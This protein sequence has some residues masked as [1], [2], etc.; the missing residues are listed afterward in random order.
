MDILISLADHLGFLFRDVYAHCLYRFSET[1][2]W[3]WFIVCCPMITFVEVPRYLVPAA[4]LMFRRFFWMIPD[5][6][7]DKRGFLG[8]TP[9]VSIL[10]V[11]LNEGDSIE[12]AIRTVLEFN[13]PDM[14]II[15]VDDNSTDDMYAKAKPYADRGQIRLF[16]NTSA[17]GR[18][19]RPTASNIA[20]A[21]ATGDY[22]LSV[23]ADTAFD[24]NLLFH[25]IGSFYKEDV[26]VVAANLKVFN[27]NESF[28]TR[29]QNLEYIQS[30]SLWKNWLNLL[31]WNMQASGACGAFRRE[32]LD[33]AG[34]WNPEL[35]EDADISLQAN[36]A[37]WRSYFC[38]Q[39]D[40]VTKV[41]ATW[42]ALVKQ[43]YRWDRGT[44][45]TYY[46]KHG[47][48]AKFWRHG[49]NNS[50]EIIFEY[51]CTVVLGVVYPAWFLWLLFSDP[52][53]LVGLISITYVFY[54]LSALVSVSAGLLSRR[55]QPEDWKCLVDCLGFPAY[56]EI[57][58]W[59]RIYATYLSLLRINYED[60]Y[61]PKTA[62]RNAPRW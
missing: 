36:K 27:I 50:G 14:E 30:I 49:W 32:C 22:I 55:S 23:D 44:V 48:M 58:R 19:G 20:L 4:V 45:R 62:W 52:Y 16:K 43:R 34:A 31:G 39:A 13:Y 53:F 1:S 60:S 37:G 47:E 18:G 38:P 8:R 59:V 25:M 40:S 57:F 21:M 51:F 35:G 7:A 41:P 11:G 61:M 10:L 24:N 6:T 56:K 5:D 29:M 2:F 12:K 17:S 26:G 42:K 54:V 46:H 15:V 28:V 9:R 33:A 3:E